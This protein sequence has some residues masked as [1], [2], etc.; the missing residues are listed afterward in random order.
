[1]EPQ[2]LQ[3]EDRVNM[4]RFEVCVRRYLSGL[5]HPDH[6]LARPFLAKEGDPLPHV[7]N[8]KALRG[9]VLMQAA[10]GSDQLPSNPNWNIAVSP[11]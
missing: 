3:E 9:T 4:D 10:S 6:P 1:M 8:P 5:G 11:L 7:D 2:L